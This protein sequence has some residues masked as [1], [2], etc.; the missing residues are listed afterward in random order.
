MNDQSPVLPCYY[1]DE[2]LSNTDVASLIA[3]LPARAWQSAAKGILEQHRVPMVLPLPDAAGRFSQTPVQRTEQVC[4][5]LR[6]AGIAAHQGRQVV[7]VVP[8]DLQWSAVFTLSIQMETGYLPYAV[9]RWARV[10]GE[11]L[12][13]PVRVIDM[14]AMMP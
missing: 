10:N 13:S 6:A 14:A 3:A 4:A 12:P 5:N 1:L 9:R 7:W 2:P 11:V 8:Q